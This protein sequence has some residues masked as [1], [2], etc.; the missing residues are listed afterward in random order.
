MGDSKELVI[1]K[2]LSDLQEKYDI[3]NLEV[4]EILDK[5]LA[6]YTLLSNETSLMVSDIEEKTHFYICLKRLEGLAES[7]LKEY[8][9][10]LR[11]LSNYICK[12]VRQIT[13]NDIRG[14]LS[15][16]KQERKLSNKTIDN[17][18]TILNGF[19]DTLLVEEII[20]KNPMS[21]IKKSKN[22]H[23]ERNREPLTAEELEIVRNNC[24]DIREKVLVEFLVSTGA[25]VS[26]ASEAKLS[27][28]DWNN[29]SIKIVGKGDKARTVFFSVKCKLY[30]QE[31]AQTRNGKS[32]SL[33]LA[34]RSPHD[35][36]TKTGIQ[37]AIKKIAK[38]TEIKKK[39]SP[40]IFRH[41]YAT[42]ALQKGMD[43]V[44]ISNL[45][46]HESVRTTEIY[47]KT[48]IKMLQIEYEK[49]IAA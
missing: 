8:W 42:L 32:D 48:N 4:K 47:A 35:P 36:L 22:S 43:I 26:E 11:M 23:K 45:L 7:S 39:I 9:Y 1:I 30:L 44:T 16:I 17:K 29:N 15:R 18:I 6:D 12:P 21:K 2:I 14:Y 19:F 34:E 28:V 31:Y 38:R 49:F 33:F 3:N 37:K 13:T 20:S 24:I 10:E 5:N 46:G 25:R 40:H 41:T 27:D